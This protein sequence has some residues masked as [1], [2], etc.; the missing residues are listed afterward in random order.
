MPPPRAEQ[1][2]WWKFCG[3]EWNH[4][5]VSCLPDI[6]LIL[7]PKSAVSILR[8]HLWWVTLDPSRQQM[9]LISITCEGWGRVLGVRAQMRLSTQ[10]W[11]WEMRGKPCPPKTC[12]TSGTAFPAGSLQDMSSS[13]CSSPPRSTAVAWSGEKSLCTHT[14]TAVAATGSVFL[15]TGS[16]KNCA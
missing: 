10:V 13:F 15:C 6:H 1:L 11:W 5:R 4:Y 9:L 12:T 8:V 7:G 3:F 2:F 14:F 16:N